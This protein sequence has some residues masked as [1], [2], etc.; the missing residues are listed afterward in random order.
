MI[1][2]IAALIVLGIVIFFHELGHF[3][4][5]KRQGIRVEQFA[6]GFP[7]KLFAFKR[8]ETEYR[9]C[10]IPL[11]GYLK[12]AGDEPNEE[13]K[14]EP[15]EFR[16][17]SVGKRMKI[18]TA[19]PFM[20]FVL[21]FVL[22]SLIAMLGV[23][24]CS[25]IVGKIEKD[26]SA[27]IAGILAGDKI[28]KIN[29]VSTNNWT[30]LIEGISKVSGKVELTLERDN[31]MI[32]KEIEVIKDEKT[33]YKEIG[34]SPYVS[35]KLKEVL[36]GYPAQKAG[37][38]KGDMVT[39]INGKQVL[40]WD[41]MAEII[42][43]N[44]GKELIFGISREGELMNIKV[45]PAAKPGY[46]ADKK[47]E[48]KVG[49]VGIL[50][51][52]EL[53]RV[54]PLVALWH[55]LQQTL[56][57][58]QVIFLILWQLICGALSYKLLAGPIGI[59]QMSGEQAQLGLTYLLGFIAMLSVNLGVVNLL[60]LPI[61]D[62]GHVLFLTIEKI[63]GKALSI[64]TQTAIQWVG[65]TLIVCLTILISNNDIRRLLGL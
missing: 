20:N 3:I 40:Q 37:L 17:A 2:M 4:A 10:A 61:L 5:A 46:D 62:G 35:T 42:R 6:I 18:V 12:M 32:T 25:N 38:K 26:S 54:N 22:F 14:G 1:T 65:I 58:I 50:S 55:G 41:E 47:K 16:S 19:G 59:V 21:G 11:G 28:I 60:P 13:L 49:S 57:T 30:E 48:I 24:T 27:Q 7:P 36:K 56:A 8:G 29:N 53:Y 31:K 15:W 43:K 51:L 33:G 34:I 44:P 64:K 63:R 39:S 9:I 23:P 52:T 45:T